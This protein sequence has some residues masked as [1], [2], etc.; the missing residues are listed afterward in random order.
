MARMREPSAVAGGEAGRMTRGA[1]PDPDPA[2]PPAAP[3]GEP[4]V[5]QRPSKRSKPRA[6]GAAIGGILAGVDQ[7]IFRAQ[8]PAQELVHHARPDDSIAASD[9]GRLRVVL[10]AD[11]DAGPDEAAAIDDDRARRQAR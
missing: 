11:A 7:Q 8:P 5:G 10:P 2:A 4:S 1:R 9:G 6:M 3:S